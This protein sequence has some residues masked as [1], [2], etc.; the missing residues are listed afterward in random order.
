MSQEL[1]SLRIDLEIDTANFTQSMQDINRGLRGINSEFKVAR[2]GSENFGSSTEDLRTK[3]DFLTRR[4]DLQRQR[5]SQ[6]KS[7][8]DQVAEAKGENSKEAENLAI[9]YNSALATM[10]NT[11]SQLASLHKEIAGA[12]W[13]QMGEDLQKAGKQLQSLG[14]NITKVGKNLTK[15]VT[16]PLLGVGAASLKVGMDFEEGMSRVE[17]LTGATEADLG[18]LEDQAR[19]MGETTRFS[20]TEAADGMGFLAM[21][22]ETGPVAEKLAA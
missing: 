16:T 22:L 6:L 18:S 14:K 19:E 13:K 9:R 12:P 1:G 7:E 2:S 11:E 10:Q 15:Y 8:Y 5:V 3:S 20:A 4:L 21:A 17:A